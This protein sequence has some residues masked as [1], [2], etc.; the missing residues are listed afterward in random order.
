MSIKRQVTESLW[1]QG[2]EPRLWVS[3]ALGRWPRW[4]L[5]CAA[6]EVQAEF[7]CTRKKEQAKGWERNREE[8][9]SQGHSLWN[10]TGC[11]QVRGSALH[12]LCGHCC[13]TPVSISSL[14]RK[15]LQSWLRWAAGSPEMIVQ[16]P[17]FSYPQCFP[18]S[19]IRLWEHLAALH[20][21]FLSIEVGGSTYFLNLPCNVLWTLFSTWIV[22]MWPSRPLDRKN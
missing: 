15:L 8:Q 16:A 5:S 9:T 7:I 12:W 14:W 19:F 21:I 1:V 13:W 4:E 3:D 11:F 20:P 6:S 2:P 22:F 10:P 18:Y 17:A